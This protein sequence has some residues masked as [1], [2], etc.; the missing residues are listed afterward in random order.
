MKGANA[1]ISLAAGLALTDFDE[2]DLWLD[3]FALGGNHPYKDL[4]AYLAGV[5]SWTTREHDRVV[6]A[7][8]EHLADQG[9]DHP[10]GYAN[11]PYSSSDENISKRQRE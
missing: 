8:N 10:V 9:L 7:L 11:D 1:G 6:L 5:Q 2:V 3:Y 4:H